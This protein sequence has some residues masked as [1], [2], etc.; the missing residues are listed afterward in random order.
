MKKLL[1]LFVAVATILTACKKG[2]E[3]KTEAEVEE[4]QIQTYIKNNSVTDLSKDSRG[5]YYK[6]LKAGTGTI[7]PD[8]AA[9]VR[10]TYN[11]KLLDGTTFE[12]TTGSTLGLAT[13]I[14]GWQYGLSHITQGGRIMLIVPSKLGYG[15]RVQSS[16]PA[17]SVLIFTIDLLGIQ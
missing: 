5:V 9:T 14:K 10:V 13:T 4:A 16:I 12:S 8:T 3:A 15:N 11:G 7:A 17:N 6:V 2:T 1:L